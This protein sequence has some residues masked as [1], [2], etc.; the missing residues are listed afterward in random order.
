MASGCKDKGPIGEGVAMV[1]VPITEMD[2]AADFLQSGAKNKGAVRARDCAQ[3]SG[4]G[5]G[6]ENLMARLCLTTAES[7]TVIID[8]FDDLEMVDPNRAFVGKVLSPN[9]LHIET[10]KSAMRPAWGNSRGL[11]FNSVGDNLFVV[12]FGS[13]ADRDRVMEGSPWRVG[14]HAVLLKFFDAD[15][16]PM[17][18]VFDRLAIWARIIKLSTRLMRAARGL[19]IAKPI[20]HV[21]RVEADDLGRCWGPYMRI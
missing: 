18:V 4:S 3:S 7:A 11:N 2:G 17:D 10:I 6:V 19:E 1:N 21:I 14:K 16:S 12:E 15:I 5:A 9:V 13:Q 20:G 8:D